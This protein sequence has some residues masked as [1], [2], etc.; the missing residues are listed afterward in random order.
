MV[1]PVPP[2]PVIPMAQLPLGSLPPWPRAVTLIVVGGWPIK[3][4]R[5]EMSSVATSLSQPVSVSEIVPR[6]PDC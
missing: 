6:E 3:T 5:G 2:P 1:V 4:V